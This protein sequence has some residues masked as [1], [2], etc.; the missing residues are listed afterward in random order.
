MF[1]G[2]GTVVKIRPPPARGKPF[3]VMD[4]QLRRVSNGGDGEQRCS[5]DER[6]R[7]AP[8]N[9]TKL[10]SGNITGG[11]AGSAEFEGGAAGL[12]EPIGART[13]IAR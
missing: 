8:H 11:A 5:I 12:T 7:A 13:T 3:G 6:P 4:A 9:A 1:W 10:R 2:S